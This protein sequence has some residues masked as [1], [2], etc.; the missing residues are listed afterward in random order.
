MA[1]TYANRVDRKKLRNIRHNQ[2]KELEGDKGK[3]FSLLTGALGI[4]AKLLHKKKT[5]EYWNCLLEEK[6]Y[7]VF[8]KNLK[9]GPR[10]LLI[11][12]LQGKNPTIFFT[13]YQI[14][15]NCISLFSKRGLGGEETLVGSSSIFSVAFN[16]GCSF[17]L[18]N[19]GYGSPEVKNVKTILYN[20]LYNNENLLYTCMAD[21]E[22]KIGY[23]VETIAL[24]LDSI[25]V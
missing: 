7:L 9:K 1:I 20:C 10:I 17:R 6:C 21:Y 4:T 18:T 19:C 15:A 16:I 22:K 25:L 24:K 5:K 8:D 13:N 3:R 11:I 2:T 23:Q 12:K 14:K